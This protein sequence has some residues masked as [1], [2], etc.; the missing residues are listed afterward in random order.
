MQSL[1]T[2]IRNLRLKNKLSQTELAH[3]INIPSQSKISAWESDNSLP[4]V[5]EAQKLAAVFDLTLEELV[6]G[7]Y[8]RD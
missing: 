7:T 8:N 4:D 2:T 6:G 1:G 5:L 3:L